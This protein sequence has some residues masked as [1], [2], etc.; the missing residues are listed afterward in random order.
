M[1]KTLDFDA[2]RADKADGI[3]VKL[4]IGGKVYDLP[5]SLPA[6]LALDIVRMHESRDGDTA[7]VKP[8]DLMRM[9]AGLF[10]GDEKFR[11]MLSDANITLNELAD[12]MK[13]IIEVYTVS[14]PQ[15]NPEGLIPTSM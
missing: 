13:M 12:L 5:A 1:V 6:N 14:D 2:F 10:G 3:P 8:D 15:P 11:L 9:G 4:T 7:K